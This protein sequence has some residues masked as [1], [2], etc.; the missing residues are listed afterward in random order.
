MLHPN[1]KGKEQADGHDKIAHL[2][3]GKFSRSGK[4]VGNGI[5]AIIFRM[6]RSVF[7]V[8]IA[9]SFEFFSCF[10]NELNKKWYRNNEGCS[11]KVAKNGNDC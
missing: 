5:N 10:Q 4:D 6:N 3:L 1:Q 2:L 9:V 7:V 8:A 11:F